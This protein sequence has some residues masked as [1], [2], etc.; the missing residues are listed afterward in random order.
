MAIVGGRYKTEPPEFLPIYGWVRTAANGQV[1]EREG[2]E[3][4]VPGKRDNGFRVLIPSS[5][6]IPYHAYHARE[7]FV[8]SWTPKMRQL[9]K[10]EPCP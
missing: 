10:V 9:A 5:H 7:S 6:L 2:F 3:P 8:L 1:A 4:S